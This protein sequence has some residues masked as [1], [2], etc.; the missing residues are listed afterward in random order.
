MLSWACKITVKA[1]CGPGDVGSQSGPEQVG[2][3]KESGV[4]GRDMAARLPG[5]CAVE[6]TG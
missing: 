4:W 5:K 2:V 1:V 6:G 3:R